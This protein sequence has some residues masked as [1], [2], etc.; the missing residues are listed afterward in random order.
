MTKVVSE[1]R[2]P[3]PKAI[4]AGLGAVLGG[5]GT[6][7]LEFATHTATTTWE[8]ILTDLI[9]AVLALLGAYLAPASPVKPG[10]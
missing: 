7:L 4:W 8:Q 2:A 1:S 10:E 6:M 3:T 9:P 5:I